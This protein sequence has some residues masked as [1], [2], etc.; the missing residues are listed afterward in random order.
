[1][2]SRGREVPIINM[3]TPRLQRLIY[4]RNDG[5]ARAHAILIFYAPLQVA[6]DT[7]TTALILRQSQSTRCFAGMLPVRLL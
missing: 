1:M 7:A 2:Y 3:A 4:T 5:F 6:R